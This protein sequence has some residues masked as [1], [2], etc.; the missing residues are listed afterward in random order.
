MSRG[1]LQ[2]C[3][4]HVFQALSEYGQSALHSLVSLVTSAV[5]VTFSTALVVLSLGLSKTF[6]ATLI[7]SFGELTG[8]FLGISISL[9]GILHSRWAIRVNVATLA[10]SLYGGYSGLFRAP[11]PQALANH[12]HSWALPLLEFL[13]DEIRSFSGE[14]LEGVIET[15]EQ[16]T[17]IIESPEFN[18]RTWPE[19]QALIGRLV[20]HHRETVVNVFEALRQTGTEGL[21]QAL[22]ILNQYAPALNSNSR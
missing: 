14:N 8:N 1:S 12:S 13:V 6:R 20:M 7:K 19:I 16:I 4:A 15:A 9:L 11:L 18:E 5:K 22:E 21:Q 10:G 2:G 17:T 3:C